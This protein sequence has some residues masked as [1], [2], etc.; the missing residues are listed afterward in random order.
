MA[1]HAVRNILNPAATDPQG[2]GNSAAALVRGCP[3]YRTVAD[4]DITTVATNGTAILGFT[5]ESCAAADEDIKVHLGYPGVQFKLDFDGTYVAT[6][7]G[8]Y[9]EITVTSG[10][11]TA[12]LEES[13]NDCLK[14]IEVVDNDSARSKYTA[15]FELATTANQNM[16]EVA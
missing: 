14:L 7:L 9:V 13:T 12:N 2:H 15:W 6:M 11:P 1:L 10:V 8:T 5:A 16:I 4:G 3:V